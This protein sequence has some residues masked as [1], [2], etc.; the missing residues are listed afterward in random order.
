MMPSNCAGLRPGRPWLSALRSLTPSRNGLASHGP[1]CRRL[2]SAAWMVSPGPPTAPI[3]AH[4]RPDG[5][6]MEA[7]EAD[8][9]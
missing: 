7:V 3:N 6:Q 9:S 2:A 8:A 5:L 1:I 4:A